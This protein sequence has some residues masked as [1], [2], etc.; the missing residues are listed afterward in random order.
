MARIEKDSSRRASSSAE[1]DFMNEM[2]KNELSSCEMSSIL[3]EM[4][5]MAITR[6]NPFQVSLN[7]DN[8][9]KLLGLYGYDLVEFPVKEEDGKIGYYEGAVK[10]GESV[11]KKALTKSQFVKYSKKS[12]LDSENQMLILKIMAWLI[13]KFNGNDSSKSGD[14]QEA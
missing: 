11:P 4:L 12:I 5:E 8:E 7:S 10:F 3:M 1:D 13:S 9:D 6:Q 14:S 2:I